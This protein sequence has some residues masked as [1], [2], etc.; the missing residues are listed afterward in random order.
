MSSSSMA[1][2]ATSLGSVLEL[3][4]IVAP[5]PGERT[6]WLQWVWSPVKVASVGEPR[7]SKA[8][9]LHR[10]RGF[11]RRRLAARAGLAAR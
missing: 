9:V 7:D 11:S 5:L 8:H 6:L 2:R 3:P 4:A 10:R 1:S